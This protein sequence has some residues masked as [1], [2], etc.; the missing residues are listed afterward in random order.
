MAVSKRLRYE[1]LRRDS[2]TCRYCGASAPDVPLR[3]DHVTPVALG[4]T[5]TPDNLVTSCEPCNSGKSSVPPDAATIADVAQDAMR[6]TVAWKQAAEEERLSSAE[7]AASTTD[8]LDAFFRAV[9]GRY[10][11]A[12][13]IPQDAEASVVRWLELGLPKE[14]IAEL[15]AY[16]VGRTAVA[17][18]SKWRYLSGCCWNALKEIEQRTRTILAEEPATAK[19]EDGDLDENEK[20]HI[21]AAVAFSRN[22]SPGIAFRELYLAV[23]GALYEGFREDR[24]VA[25][26]EWG[27]V[28]REPDITLFLRPADTYQLTDEQR[29]SVDAIWDAWNTARDRADPN[30]E[31][32]DDV[33]QGRL[34]QSTF[35]AFSRGVSVDDVLAAVAMGGRFNDP[36][37][38]HFLPHWSPRLERI[39]TT[40]EI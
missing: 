16:T 25:A 12:P 35:A 27:S 2:H 4:G 13:A 32:A 28:L 22:W 26:A 36:N 29:T 38:T 11:I 17:P 20:I 21:A 37:I 19:S 6:W 18:D 23:E 33:T 3:I 24:I 10:G 14:K 31:P 34:S 30:A 5:D 7:R 8:V 39:K 1:I 40:Q 15:I 9:K